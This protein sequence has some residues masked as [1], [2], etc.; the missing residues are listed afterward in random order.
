MKKIILLVVVLSVLLADTSAHAVLVNLKKNEVQRRAALRGV[1][2]TA[3]SEGRAAIPAV[4]TKAVISWDLDGDG[5]IDRDEAK[6]IEAY[7][8]DLDRYQPI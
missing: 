4:Y 3:R 2:Q 6:R 8:A 7:L 5:Y 1:A